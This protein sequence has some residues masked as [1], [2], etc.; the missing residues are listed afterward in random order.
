MIDTLRLNLVDCDIKKSAPLQIV[1][2]VIDNSSGKT[3]NNNDLFIDNA[4]KI[5]TGSKAFLNDDKF[6][7]TIQ[8]TVE[9]EYTEDNKPIL[10]QKRFKRLHLNDQDNFFD[11][12]S[13]EK[14]KGIFVTTSLPRLLNENNFKALNVF[15]QKQALK[16]LEQKL[17]TYGIRTNIDNATLSRVDTFTNIKTE[18][19]FYAYSNLF[20]LMECSRMKSVGWGDESFLWKNGN[21]QLAVYDKIN[22]QRAKYPKQPLPGERNIM[23]F[24]NR[25]LKKRSIKSKLKLFKVDEL[26]KNYD[27]I[28]NY[29]KN[30]IEKNIFKYTIDDIDSLTIK[31][32]KTKFIIAKKLY[33]KRWFNQ[34]CFS[35]GVWTIAK[36]ADDTFLNDLVEL[37]DEGNKNIRMKKSRIKKAIQDAKMNFAVG[38]IFYDEKITTRSNVELY[39]ELK[40]KFYKEVA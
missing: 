12:E 16:I 22:E 27:E 31:D 17:R 36:V 1:P 33:G 11:N 28:K 9:S 7:L 15:E 29:H 25:L 5:V 26:F 24:E 4:G 30:E 23:R 40:N 2:G 39:N 14:V 10:K 18:F 35:L 19:N 6:N 34:Y 32:L 21:Q 38:G 37:L 13:D 20:A 3:Y 8:P